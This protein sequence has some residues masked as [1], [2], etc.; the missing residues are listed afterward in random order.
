[1]PTF[2]IT[3]SG[4]FDLRAA[5]GFGFGP[6]AGAETPAE[7]RMELAF[8]LD[9]LDGHAGVTLVQDSDG[10]VH[11]EIEGTDELD[12]VRRQVA[13]VLSLDGDGIAF[14][15]IGERDPVLGELQAQQPGLR[16]VLFHSP[17]EAAAWGIIS[18]RRSPAQGAV[19]R[20]ALAE[21]LGRVLTAGAAFPTPRRLLEA[22]PLPG[23]PEVKVQRL[24]A[25][26]RADARRR[27]GP[28]DPARARSGRRRR[29]PPAPPGHRPLLRDA[30]P[31]PRQRAPRP[32][33]G[34]RAAHPRGSAALLRSRPGLH[35]DRRGL[36]P[37]PDLG[38]RPAALRGAP[39]GHRARAVGPTPR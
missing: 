3:P 8:C 38:Q 39:R 37:L 6:R 4:Q 27:A 25:L 21:R 15:A 26:A 32:A 33:P 30:R 29:A 28:A 1:V 7:A 23:L 2:T 36:A 17:Y 20:Q 13:R 35:G 22:E 19:V 9:A 5:A 10:V 24:H 16:P 14:A 34:R 11:G 12:A 31:G 18:A